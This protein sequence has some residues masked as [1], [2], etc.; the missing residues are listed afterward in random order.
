MEKDLKIK[1]RDKLTIKG[2]LYGRST[3]KLVVFL[4]GLTDVY[5]NSYLIKRSIEL[6]LEKGYSVFAYNQ[7]SD[8]EKDGK[9]PRALYEEVTL[10]RHKEDSEDV[11]NFFKDQHKNI[12]LIGHSFGG[13]TLNRANIKCQSQAFWDP[14]FHAT[15]W[16]NEDDLSYIGNIPTVNWA[17]Q[18]YIV[19]DF[20]IKDAE[21]IT[22]EVAEKWCRALQTPTLV[23]NTTDCNDWNK[24]YKDCLPSH[25][26][27]E[28][29]QTSHTFHHLGKVEELCEKTHEFFNKQKNK[30]L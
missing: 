7:Y 27:F 17:G 13:L 1:A 12:F 25:S 26:K 30:E 18:K 6:F 15:G 3:D 19:N 10:L 2:T 20:M 5:Q 11:F 16:G 14:T 21:Q 24:D 9:K 28:T 29:M 4:H 23:I 22:K 8:E